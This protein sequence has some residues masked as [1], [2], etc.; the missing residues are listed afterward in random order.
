[1]DPSTIHETSHGADAH[2]SDDTALG[3]GFS[4]IDE[5]ARI[6]LPKR[7]RQLLGAEPG[8]SIRARGGRD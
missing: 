1:M 6:S 3:A 7:L 4:V 8:S 2:G 5:K